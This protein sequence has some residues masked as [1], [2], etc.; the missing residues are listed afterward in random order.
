MDL[1][2]NGRAL[3]SWWV[4]AGDAQSADFVFSVKAGN[5]TDATRPT[6]GS[7]PIL[8]YTSPQ[9]FVTAGIL[10]A[11]GMQI[12]I[13]SLPR[14]F[15]P[16]GGDLTLELSPSLGTYLLDATKSLPEPDAF[17]SNEVIASY[18][19]ANLSVIPALREAGTPATEL[20]QRQQSIV[21][22]GRASCRERV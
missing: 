11:A 14:S 3:V 16:L 15:T 8:R 19:M 18:L 12:E 20:A 22:I 9:A 13:V 1:P 10:P 2:A 7:I 17:S 5:L 4:S 6:D 21:E